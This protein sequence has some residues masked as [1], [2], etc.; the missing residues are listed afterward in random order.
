MGLFAYVEKLINEHGS[1]GILRDRIVLLEQQHQVDKQK[2]EMEHDALTGQLRT[3]TDELDLARRE[4]NQT[5]SELEQSKIRILQLEPFAVKAREMAIAV[6]FRKAML[7]SGY[8][9][10]L[11]NKTPKPLALN[12]TVADATRQKNQQFR[13][14]VDG[15]TTMGASF[16]AA[17]AKEIGHREG[18]AFAKGDA[19]EVACAGYDSLHITVP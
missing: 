6:G 7:G 13:V 9:L 1:S 15:G 18:W 17:P 3:V 16:N 11:Q 8:V 19:V 4:L 14:V 2:L 12:V 5:K 10:T